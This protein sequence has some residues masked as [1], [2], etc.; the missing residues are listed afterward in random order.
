MWEERERIYFLKRQRGGSRA[1]YGNIV[2]APFE[3]ERE[4]I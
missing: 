3:G 2:V 1:L 4:P